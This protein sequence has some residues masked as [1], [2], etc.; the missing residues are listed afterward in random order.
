M[1][2]KEKLQELKETL[3]TAKKI[4]KTPARITF[5]YINYNSIEKRA[6][7]LEMK[8]SFYQI[9]YNITRNEK[10]LRKM[11]TTKNKMNKVLQKVIEFRQITN[12]IN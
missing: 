8:S 11:K 12:N 1:N 7:K 6:F 10:D 9:K 2:K 5:K 3:K 4:I